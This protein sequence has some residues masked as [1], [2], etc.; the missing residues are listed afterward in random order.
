L[1]VA[2]LLVATTAGPIELPAVLTSTPSRRQ[3][4]NYG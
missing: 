1:R 4:L 3:L 2:N